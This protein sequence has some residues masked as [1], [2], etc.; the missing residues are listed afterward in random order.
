MDI[1]Q[2]KYAKTADGV[3]V[4]YEVVGDGPVDLV[5]AFRLAL[6]RGCNVVPSRKW[7]RSSD[8]WP[9]SRD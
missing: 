5:F 1:P 4:A 6:E 7:R 2:T 9:R 3:Y 8:T